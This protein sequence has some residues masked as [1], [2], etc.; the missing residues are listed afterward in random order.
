[1][2]L[3]Y[4]MLFALVCAF[5]LVHFAGKKVVPWLHRLHFGQ[6][7]YD[8]GPQTHK[9]KQGTPI[10]GGMMTA[11]ASVLCLLVFHPAAWYG[12]WDFAVGLLLISLLC[13][14]VG[15]AD[16]YIKSMKKR[17]DGLTPWQKIAGQTAAAVGFSCYCSF[18]PSVGSSI[19]I[20][21]TTAEWDLGIL[22]IPLMAFVIIFMVNSSNLLDGLDGLLSTSSTVGN[23][24]WTLIALFTVRYAV[25]T[26]EADNAGT[27]AI[28][29]LA[30]A[31]G[32]MGFLRYNRFPARC[33]QGDSGSMFIGG[34]TVGLALLLRQPILM[35]LINFTMVIS[36]VSVILQRAYFKLTHGK[37]IFKMSPLHHHFELCGYPETQIVSM[38]AIITALLTIT[39]VISQYAARWP[40]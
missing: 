30:V 23:L 12:F 16:D 8:L 15:F 18:N 38:Y 32:T 19:R 22:Y 24:G 33:F 3:A 34:V 21:F 1:M 13:M 6:T 11:A 2:N 5:L 39:A 20:P 14:A 7:I 9:S 31:G 28:F 4:R 40:Y 29:A 37:R 10:M 27:A 36:S 26:A 25:G 17:H 35:L